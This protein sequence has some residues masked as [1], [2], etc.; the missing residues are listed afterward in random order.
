MRDGKSEA[1]GEFGSGGSGGWGGTGGG[2]SPEVSDDGDMA[3]EQPGTLQ[4][5]CIGN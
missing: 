3:E 1:K 2:P 4:Q 5:L